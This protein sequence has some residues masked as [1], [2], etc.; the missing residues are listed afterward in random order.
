MAKP[1][2]D[3]KQALEDIRSGLDDQTLMDKY[4]ISA[5]GLQSLFGKLID[6]GVITQQEIDQR[7]SESFGDVSIT[8]N[9]KQQVGLVQAKGSGRTVSAHEAARD[10]RSGVSDADL[11]KKYRLSSKGLQSLFGQLLDT[12]V[13]SQHDL[14]GRMPWTD[15][16]VDV[17]GVLR[18]FGLDRSHVSER[19]PTVPSQCVACGAPQTMEFEVCPSCGTNIPEFKTRKVEREQPVKA[20]WLCPACGRPQDREY[21]ECPV[22]GVI[23]TKFLR[24]A[25]YDREQS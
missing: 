10:L 18:Q 24:K 14:D 22:C 20:A 9:L 17:L 5:K 8:E 16:T 23:V 4:R 21:E 12:G 6:F 2:I 15:H 13:V 3:A 25:G 11:M 19:D 7:T 1:K